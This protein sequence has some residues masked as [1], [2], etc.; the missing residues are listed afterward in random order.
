MSF[1]IHWPK[2]EYFLE[3]FIFV[4]TQSNGI[5]FEEDLKK[6]IKHGKFIPLLKSDIL[7]ALKN[8]LFHFGFKKK[9]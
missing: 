8:D 7:E 1:G 9:Y 3:W 4:L 6:N 2:E 5:E